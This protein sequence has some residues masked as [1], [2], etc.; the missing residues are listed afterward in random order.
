MIEWAECIL[1]IAWWTT[2]MN[3]YYLLPKEKEIHFTAH[4]AHIS[5]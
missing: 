5:F 2:G 4:I 1:C 3:A